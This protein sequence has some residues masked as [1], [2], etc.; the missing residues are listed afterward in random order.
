MEGARPL[1]VQIQKYQADSGKKVEDRRQRGNARIGSE[2]LRH[3]GDGQQ[4]CRGMGMPRMIRRT[5]IRV[6]MD[7]DL[8]IDDVRMLEKGYPAQIPQ[9]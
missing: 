9:E 4:L 6:R 2:H 5:G 7:D 3:L 8:P 1:R